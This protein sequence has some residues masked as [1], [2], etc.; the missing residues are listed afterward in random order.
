M[1]GGANNSEFK[2]A[3]LLSSCWVPDADLSG[4]G[5]IFWE[6]YADDLVHSGETKNPN[7]KKFH[8]DYVYF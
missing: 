3:C 4:G 7:I 8:F 5:G 2:I 1:G 6:Y